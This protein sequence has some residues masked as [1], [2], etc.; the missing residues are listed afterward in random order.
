MYTL[1]LYKILTLSFPLII[2]KGS[3]FV[4]FA[5]KT[6]L[7]YYHV[8]ERGF[9]KISGIF[10]F[11]MIFLKFKHFQKI[12]IK[13]NFFVTKNGGNFENHHKSL[14]GREVGFKNSYK[15]DYVINGHPLI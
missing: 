13:F 4:Y 10:I 11:Y 3:V 8:G 14:R 2:T 15:L 12:Y 7:Y 6:F 1:L 5:I 9:N